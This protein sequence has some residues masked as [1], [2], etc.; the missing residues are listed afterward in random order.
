PDGGLRRPCSRRRLVAQTLC[1]AA[2]DA[3]AQGSPCLAPCLPRL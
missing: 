2:P 3:E 1:A